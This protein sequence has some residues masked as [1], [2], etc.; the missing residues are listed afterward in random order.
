MSREEREVGEE[1]AIVVYSPQ[2]RHSFLRFSSRPSRDTFAANF[3]LCVP[4]S[5]R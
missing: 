5:L 4:A 1:K 2:F 3:F